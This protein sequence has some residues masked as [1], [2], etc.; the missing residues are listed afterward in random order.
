MTSLY[1]IS[2]DILRIFADV[3]TNDGEIT[4]EQYEQ[5]AIRQDELK[6]KLEEYVKAIKEFE[7]DANLCKDEKKRI[8][9]RQN[10]YKNRVERLKNAVLNAVIEFGEQGKTN[11]FIEL[12]T[13]RLSTRS[14][15]SVEVDK[16]RIDKFMNEFERYVRELVDSGVIY[17]GEDVDIKGILHSINANCVAMYGEAFECFSIADLTTMKITISQ[18]ASVYDLFRRG[19]ALNLYGKEPIHTTMKEDT[20]L[21]DWKTKIQIAKEYNASI[22]TVA[23]IK[24]KDNLQIK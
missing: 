2:E 7:S 9:D 6:T 16:D 21:D 10:V 12:P 3:E 13:C 20:S 19:G 4:D 14:S 18:T 11:K 8:N 24:Y 5:L 17:T 15:T 1:N 23:E 22:P